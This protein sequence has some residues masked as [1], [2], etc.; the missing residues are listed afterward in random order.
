MSNANLFH[1]NPLKIATTLTVS[2]NNSRYMHANITNMDHCM[3]IIAFNIM[4]HSVYTTY[5]HHDDNFPKRATN[6]NIK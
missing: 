1:L 3:V 5:I 2:Y 6:S 4:Q